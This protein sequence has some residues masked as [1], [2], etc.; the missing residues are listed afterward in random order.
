MR[1]REK[2]AAFR[3]SEGGNVLMT[4]ALSITVLLG[5]AGLGTEV[6]S[7][8]S[9]R[10]DMQNASDLGA[11]SGAISL[12]ANYPGSAMDDGYAVKEAKGATGFHGYLNGANGVTVTVNI[13]PLSGSYTSSAYDHLAVEV[14]VSKPVAPLFSGL[15][16]SSGPTVT[17][18]SVA[19]VTASTADCLV[20]LDPTASAALYFQGAVTINVPCGMAS[21]STDKASIS[22]TGGAAVINASVVRSGGGIDD[23]HGDISTPQE[24]TNDS[25]IGDPYAARKMPTLAANYPTGSTYPGDVLTTVSPTYSYTGDITTASNISTI[26]PNGCASGC[27][28]HGN[29]NVSGGTVNLGSGVIFVDSG[30]STSSGNVSIGA[31]GTLD[32]SGATI[33]L[34]SSTGT[35]VG[36]FNMQ[37]AT[38]AVNMSAPS[39]GDAVTSQTNYAGLAGIALMQDRL[40]TVSSS[41]NSSTFQGGPSSTFTGA[42][43]FPNGNLTWQ[44]SPVTTACFQVIADT[45]DFA[46]SVN[47]NM[48]N[49]TGGEIV[50]GPQS[51]SLV[52]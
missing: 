9:L 4:F 48:S 10:R 34:T 28:I 21:A 49:C 29:V 22:V 41:T 47:L 5:A 16:L 20:A 8:Y 19:L 2:L 43:Y 13:P 38:A 14:I 35:N 33:I 52:E 37:S 1:L 44:G 23:K 26:F 18:R 50:G 51:V 39:T 42:L 32:T 6:A 46:G 12:K 30:G 45:L 24:I 31:N 17:A 7:W 15:F 11:S 40:A 27:V 25:T 3:R 36:T